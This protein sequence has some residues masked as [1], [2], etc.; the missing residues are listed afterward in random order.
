MI[1]E[2]WL[3][4]IIDISNPILAHCSDE[5]LKTTYRLGLKTFL[6]LPISTPSSIVYAASQ[7]MT[8]FE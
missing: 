6:G 3:G 2:G 7:P 1:F 5:K 8:L 4:E